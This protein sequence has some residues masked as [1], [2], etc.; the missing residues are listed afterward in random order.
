MAPWPAVA[1]A[2]GRV[3]SA[4]RV[5]E[6]W[7]AVSSTLPRVWVRDEKP[8]GQPPAGRASTAAD[9]GVGGFG[10]VGAGGVGSWPS[11]GEEMDESEHAAITAIDT[12]ANS[13]LI[14]D[15]WTFIR[16]PPEGL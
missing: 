10:L 2:P 11:P 12:P 3:V 4:R 16:E 13:S 7:Q 15:I 5:P 1:D 9:G 6:V 14:L 8:V